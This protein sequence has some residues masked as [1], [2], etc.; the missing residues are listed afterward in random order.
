MHLFNNTGRNRVHSQRGDEVRPISPSHVKTN[1]TRFFVSFHRRLTEKWTLHTTPGRNQSR[2]LQSTYRPDTN[3][4][5]FDTSTQRAVPSTDCVSF[6]FPNTP[7]ASLSQV[8]HNASNSKA[9]SVLPV[10][11]T[12]AATLGSN[13]LDT[14]LG[15]GPEPSA[16]EERVGDQAVAESGRLLQAISGISATWGCVDGAW[17]GGNRQGVGGAGRGGGG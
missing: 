9:L 2:R 6:C 15:T 17:E 3:R 8:I 4:T 14:V 5:D 13:R 1:V 16:S 7:E 10:S 11:D 12:H